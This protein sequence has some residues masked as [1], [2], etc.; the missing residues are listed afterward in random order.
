MREQVVGGMGGA[1]GIRT[2]NNKGI[3]KHTTKKKEQPC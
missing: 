2:T 3:L 1:G